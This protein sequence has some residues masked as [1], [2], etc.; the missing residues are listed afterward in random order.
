MYQAEFTHEGDRC[1]FE[2]LVAR[3]GLDEPAPRWPK[4]F[5]TST[6][7]GEKFCRPET[8]S[9]P[10]CAFASIHRYSALEAGRAVF[11]GPTPVRR[12]NQMKWVLGA[13]KVIG[14]LVSGTIRAH[15]PGTNSISFRRRTS[16]ALRSR[17]KATRHD[18][19][20]VELSHV[21]ELCSFDAFIAKYSLGSDAALEQLATTSARDTARLDIAPQCAGPR[22]IAGAVPCRR[23][24]VA[25]WIHALR[26]HTPGYARRARETQLK[27]G[28]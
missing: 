28:C 13:A 2:T 15:Q 22:G 23:P 27:S 19:D 4:S 10:F 6:L 24:R 7:Q 9:K 20:G 1:T 11:D 14:S 12:R 25:P 16:H 21:G 17:R 26:A 5:T 18:V 3:F 8:A